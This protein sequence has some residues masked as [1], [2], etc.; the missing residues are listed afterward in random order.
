MLF[1]QLCCASQ[2]SEALDSEA[3]SVAFRINIGVADDSRGGSPG[4]FAQDAYMNIDVHH[5][6][7]QEAVQGAVHGAVHQ[8]SMRY[9]LGACCL[10]HELQLV[11]PGS[12]SMQ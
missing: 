4:S 6:A 3:P 5:E 2:E 10:T 11:S 9:S 8:V 1:V 12:I 7:V